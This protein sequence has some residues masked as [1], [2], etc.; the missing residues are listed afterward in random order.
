MPSLIWT[1]IGRSLTMFSFA[2][3]CYLKYW[4][5]WNIV[6]RLC[7]N[8][9]FSYLW[10]RLVFLNLLHFI[11]TILFNRKLVTL[12]VR[13]PS[14]HNLADFFTPFVPE[15]VNCF[16]SH[17]FPS[18]G[19]INWEDKAWITKAKSLLVVHGNSPLRIFPECF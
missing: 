12:C 8:V 11:F 14:H 1:M 18:M 17:T 13:S 2:K 5:F 19:I 7:N 9:F 6:F 3:T 15:Y 16:R 4:F 10:N